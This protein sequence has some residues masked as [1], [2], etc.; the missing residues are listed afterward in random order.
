MKLQRRIF[1][2]TLLIC[3]FSLFFFVAFKTFWC[4]CDKDIF[5][6]IFIGIFGSSLLVLV[7]ALITF[8]KVKAETKQ[9]II[10]TFIKI[11]NLVNDLHFKTVF[12]KKDDQGYSLDFS[13]EKNR[14]E[15][16]TNP[17]IY[18][19]KKDIYETNVRKIESLYQTITEI[20]KF[21]Y[22]FFD[23]LLPDYISLFHNEKHI[24]SLFNKYWDIIRSVMISTY[25]IPDAYGARQYECCNAS[26]G[27][28]FDIWLKG[29]LSKIEPLHAKLEGL[30]S[31]LLLIKINFDMI[32]YK[33]V[34][35]CN[36]KAIITT[37]I[38]K[39]QT[40]YIE[41]NMC[42]SRKVKKLFDQIREAP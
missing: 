39:L 14:F 21:D 15:N 42:P 19:A 20:D 28:F 26:T 22:S 7:P 5:S 3:V 10:S 12:L 24:Q 35:N 4:E 31:I 34:I 25:Q 36:D 32:S 23:S 1:W 29:F 9:K 6:N 17:S 37:A 11:E 27:Q 16:A 40:F 18:L 8:H 13:F 33:S 30:K 2:T 38:T 41:N